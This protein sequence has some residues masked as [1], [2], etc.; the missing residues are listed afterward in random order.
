MGWQVRQDK[1]PP[2]TDGDNIQSSEP[3]S[4]VLQELAQRIN[5]IHTRVQE[6][7]RAAGAAM[8]QEV[9]SLPSGHAFCIG[10][11]PHSACT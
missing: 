7:E 2:N 10:L 6:I 4:V 11:S 8:S 1:P 3:P 9:S 5:T